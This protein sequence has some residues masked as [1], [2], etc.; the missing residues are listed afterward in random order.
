MISY[1]TVRKNK[2]LSQVLVADSD[3]KPKP[4]ESEAK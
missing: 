2:T 4:N 1:N 3:N